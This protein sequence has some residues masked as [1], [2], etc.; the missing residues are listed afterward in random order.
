MQTVLAFGEILWDVFGED[1]KIGGAPLNFAAHFA[2][3]GGKSYMVSAVGKDNLGTD[4]LDIVGGFGIDTSYVATLDVP[5][6]RCNVTLKGGSPLYD[7]QTGVAYDYIPM[8]HV[9][10]SFD[11]LYYGSLACRNA[12]SYQ[13][14]LDIIKNADVKE[15]FFDVN[16]R[17][18][19]YTSELLDTLTKSA[20]ILKIS[21]E[22]MNVYG[23][24][25]PETVAKALMQK[26]ANLRLVIVTLDKD[27]GMLVAR[28]GSIVYS[29]KPNVVPVST[30]GGGD[31]FSACMLI[32]LL[33]GYD[34]K[35]ALDRAATLADYV[36]TQLGAI[37][38]YSIDLKLKLGISQS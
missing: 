1:S 13:T 29:R 6:G 2:K 36:V 27:G 7:L 31:S 14:L 22:E 4:A 28:D 20:T 33:N 24:G 9:T 38:D 34:Y 32:S 3:L 35:P 18:N 23:I 16:I 19:Y 5:T 10:E 12:V 25:S 15:R 8:P 30:V 37:P 11:A 17:Q 26:Y 21:R